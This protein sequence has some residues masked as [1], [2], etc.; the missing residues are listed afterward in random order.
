MNTGAC[1]VNFFI[2]TCTYNN[3]YCLCCYW[4]YGK[5]RSPV[6]VHVIMHTGRLPVENCMIRF[7]IIYIYLHTNQ[8][9]Y[10][11]LSLFI[12]FFY[13]FPLILLCFVTFFFFSNIK[14]EREGVVTFPH[15]LNLN[16]PKFSLY[17]PFPHHLSHAKKFSSETTVCESR[18]N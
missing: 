17:P 13:L 9:K 10:I 11:I 7:N 16:P 12:Y 4:W 8:A 2:T 1:F 6:H 5:K 18:T 14:G 3:S 15:L